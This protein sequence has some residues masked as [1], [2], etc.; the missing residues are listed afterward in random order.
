VRI[1]L[2][3]G[4]IGVGNIA[5]RIMPAFLQV[6]D[7]RVIAVN[8][9]DPGK[10]RVFCSKWNIKGVYDDYDAMLADPDINIVYI[11]TPHLVHHE[12]TLKALRA[13]KHVLCEKPMAMSEAE[14]A[15]L[16]REA[17]SA[18]V[19]L[20][21][22]LWTRFFP[23]MVWLRDLIAGGRLG[24]PRNVM[25]DFC[26][27][28]P[29]NPAYRMFNR[30]LGGGSMLSAGIYPFSMAVMI[31]GGPPSEVTAIGDMRG[32]V[33]L[34]SGALMRFPDGGTAQVYTGFQGESAHL[35]NISF[36]KG[37]VLIPEFV[38]P[39]RGT[40]IL[41]GSREREEVYMHY[42]QPGFQFELTHIR[43]CIRQGK[44][45]SPVV[46][47]AESIALAHLSDEMYRQMRAPDAE[48]PL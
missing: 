24:R 18:G 25:A 45:E 1:I 37:A 42:E 33:D 44:T 4:F 32:G 15:D 6:P 34:R 38:Y 10:T 30:G 41:A 3:W 13:G 22:G 19:F 26:F 17:R 29:Y 14:T 40:I 35:L 31:F 46:P 11:A 2:N 5:E 16:A 39:D 48:L 7:M 47:L 12:H 21:E 8:G 9:R 28:V 27:E 36:E 20:M 43:E 23:I